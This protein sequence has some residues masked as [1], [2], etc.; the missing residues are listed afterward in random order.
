MRIF[1]FAKIGGAYKLCRAD[2]MEVD[3]LGNLLFYVEGERHKARRLIRVYAP[4]KWDEALEITE[5]EASKFG[6]S[7]YL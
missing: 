6:K 7:N 2:Q 5:E 1:K 4:E 3:A